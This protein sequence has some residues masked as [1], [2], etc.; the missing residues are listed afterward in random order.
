MNLLGSNYNSEIFSLEKVKLTIGVF[1]WNNLL[2]LIKIVKKWAE[3]PPTGIEFIVTD[4]VGMITLES[5]ENERLVCFR[6]FKVGEAS[7]VGKIELSNNGL[8]GQTR[9]F[10]VHF[11][12]D[13][14]IR[15][16]SN[17][18]LVP[19]DFLE[20]PRG[21]VLELNANFGL[22]LIQGWKH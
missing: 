2:V 11:D 9:K 6:D 10:R 17:N 12:V 19:R 21:N 20:N 13:G 1:H 15:L 8:H 5:I 3:Y 18:K 16:D 4:K 7:A 22:L 14:L